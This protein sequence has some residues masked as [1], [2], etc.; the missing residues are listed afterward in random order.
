MP[1]RIIDLSMPIENDIISD[2]PG[3]GTRAVA[4]LDE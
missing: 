3:C 2:P 1:R 4:I